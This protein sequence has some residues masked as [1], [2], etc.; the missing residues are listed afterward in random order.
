MAIAAPVFVRAEQGHQAVGFGA[1]CVFV[2]IEDRLDQRDVMSGRFGKAVASAVAVPEAPAVG[3]QRS[4][5]LRGEAVVGGKRDRLVQRLVGFEE[6]ADV[7]RDHG[8]VHGE[9]RALQ[10]G[11]GVGRQPA[12]RRPRQQHLDA[13]PGV[14]DLGPVAALERR[15]RQ[16][17]PRPHRHQPFPRKPLY[18]LAHRRAS[19]SDPVDERAFGGDAARGEL[20]HDDHA[21]QRPIG[22]GGCRPVGFV[23]GRG[24]VHVV[25]NPS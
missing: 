8:R 6:G 17:R 2:A 13:A 7:A 10:R 24:P 23:C 3:L 14:D 1:G 15:D 18:R 20:Q 5:E 22:A 19:E 12:R 4:G 9:R 25:L 11:D 21:L 16:S